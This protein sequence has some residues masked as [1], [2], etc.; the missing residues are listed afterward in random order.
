L[1]VPL[2]AFG[3]IQAIGLAGMPQDIYFQIGLLTLVG[4]AAKNAILIVEFGSALRKLGLPLVQ[5]TLE[6][7]RLR[8]RPIMMTSLTFILGVLPLVLST[9]AGASGRRS[10]GTGVLGGMISATV[11][12]VLFVPV[13]FLVIQGGVEWIARRLGQLT[14]E[15]LTSQPAPE[16]ALAVVAAILGNSPPPASSHLP[17]H[18]GEEADP[19]ADTQPSLPAQ[20]DSK[21]AGQS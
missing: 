21:S 16:E 7:A 13:F 4:L 14:A 19:G 15:P 11:L 2:G 20:H 12:A 6:A 5:A 18:R 8:L 17:S 10:I 1:A 3:A 9:G